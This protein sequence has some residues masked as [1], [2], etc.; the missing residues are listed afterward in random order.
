M[1][2]VCPKH[3]APVRPEPVEGELCR[4][5]FDRLSTNGF[6]GEEYVFGIVG[7]LLIE[8]KE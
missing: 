3:F 8:L 4:S 2:F 1:L 7:F 5:R 6:V